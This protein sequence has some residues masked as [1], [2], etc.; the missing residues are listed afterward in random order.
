MTAKI[1]QDPSPSCLHRILS[2]VLLRSFVA[3]AIQ[4][5]HSQ[6]QKH[7]MQQS[8][9]GCAATRQTVCSPSARCNLPSTVSS[10]SA[11]RHC[12][13]KRVCIWQRKN[14]I[15]AGQRG[16]QPADRHAVR[17]CVPRA[18]AIGEQ[19]E[20]LAPE[21]NQQDSS[22]WQEFTED[23]ILAQASQSAYQEG[24]SGSSE[25]T[26]SA[27]SAAAEA[28]AIAYAAAASAQAER[29]AVIN[30]QQLLHEVARRRNFAIISHPDAGK[31]TLTEKLLLY[32]GA[33][34]EAGEVGAL[35][36]N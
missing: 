26:L 30:L 6:I 33:I 14:A 36:Q 19:A 27:A 35:S 9:R 32:G 13:L 20:T 1:T 21:L 16:T 28:G 17:M 29:Q 15:S 5:M 7:T 4:G 10:P 22:E 11:T 24:S 18:S 25:E 23:D 12:S 34:H 31:T 3:A 8:S 2:I